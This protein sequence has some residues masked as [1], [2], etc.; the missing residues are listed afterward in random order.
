M[1]PKLSLSQTKFW[2]GS[3]SQSGQKTLILILF[4]ILQFS[5]TFSTTTVQKGGILF[6]GI[7]GAQV[8]GEYMVYKRVAET[9]KLEEGVQAGADLVVTYINVCNRVL[10][11]VKKAK[12]KPVGKN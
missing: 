1:N 9:A 11:S 3:L 4:L 6:E 10:D 5:N 12:E 7:G 8:N 2:N